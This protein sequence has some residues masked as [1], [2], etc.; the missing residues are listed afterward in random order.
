MLAART[1]LRWG[2]LLHR[3]YWRCRPLHAFH[4]FLAGLCVVANSVR[5]STV[6]PSPLAGGSQDLARAWTRH[7]PWLSCWWLV[8]PQCSVPSCCWFCPRKSG[9]SQAAPLQAI[10][11]AC[12]QP[13]CLPRA[14]WWG[15]PWRLQAPTTTRPLRKTSPS[16][17]AAHHAHPCYASCSRHLSEATGSYTITMG[18]FTECTPCGGA[19]NVHAIP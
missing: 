7:G 1:A 4:H 10:M 18:H 17:A 11:R 19:W 6:L 12:L 14:S 2:L 13:C 8:Q 3:P 15:P 16:Q 9:G 5:H